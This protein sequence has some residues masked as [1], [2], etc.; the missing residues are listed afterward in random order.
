MKLRLISIALIAG[1]LTAC[2]GG[3]G[4]SNTS[5]PAPQTRTLQGVAIDGYISGATAFLDINYN[6]VLDEGE[7]SSVTDRARLRSP[8][9]CK[10][11][12]KVAI[13]TVCFFL[14][15]FDPCFEAGFF[16]QQI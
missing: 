9:Y 4:G 5:A 13:A 12:R 2:G 14:L 1:C 16:R 7:P 8:L 15:S 10:D 3:G 6:G 11:L